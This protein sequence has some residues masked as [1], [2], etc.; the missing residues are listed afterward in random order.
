MS[1]VDRT[2]PVCREITKTR[3]WDEIRNNFQFGLAPGWPGG[4][5]VTN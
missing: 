1:Q 3:S 2:G 5:V 4:L